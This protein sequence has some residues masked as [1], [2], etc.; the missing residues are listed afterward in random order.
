VCVPVLPLKDESDD[1][2]HQP[3]HQKAP[4]IIAED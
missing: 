3:A 2:D 1:A 4:A